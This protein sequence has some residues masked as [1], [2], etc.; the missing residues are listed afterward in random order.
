MRQD[1]EDRTY[2]AADI[3]IRRAIQRIEQHAIPRDALAVLPQDHRLLVFLRCD[4]GDA[5]SAAQTAQQ[6][7]VGDY[8]EL[9]LD[10]TLNVFGADTAENI[11][12]P[13][14]ANLVRDDFRGYRQRGKDPEKS[15]A[16]LRMVDLLFENV[17]LERHDAHVIVTGG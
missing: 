5:L 2:T 17:R 7:L 14:A 13:C 16:G 9:L 1:A 10:L 15:P 6:H 3:E 11:F 4:D 12:Q 8:V